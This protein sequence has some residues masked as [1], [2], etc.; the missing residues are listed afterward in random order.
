MFSFSSAILSCFGISALYVSSVF[1]FSKLP[2]EDVKTIKLRIISVIFVSAIS[3][4]PFYT[5][6]LS[7]KNVLPHSCLSYLGMGTDV[8]HV[9]AIGSTLYLLGSLYAGP[10]LYHVYTFQ[11]FQGLIYCRQPWIAIRTLIVA[12]TSEEWVFR[13]CITPLLILQGGV[14]PERACFLVPLFFGAAHLHHLF[15]LV[16]HQRKALSAAFVLVLFQF[17]FTSL[18][19]CFG[20][21]LFVRTGSIL[22]PVLAHSFC[23]F[24]GLPQLTAMYRHRNAFIMLFSTFLSLILFFRLIPEMLNTKSFNSPFY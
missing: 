7:E 3:W 16:V 15:D 6:Y 13:A 14:N 21:F 1:I 22:A 18:F 5:F 12:P 24:F 11:P 9:R 2:R 10:L 23:N 8:Q 4:Y 17:I 20:C 19:G